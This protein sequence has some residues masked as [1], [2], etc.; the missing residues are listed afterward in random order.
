MLGIDWVLVAALVG[1]GAKA[2][3]EIVKVVWP[4]KAT[5]VDKWQSIFE[6]A[7]RYVEG[8]KVKEPLNSQRAMGEGWEVVKR[9]F[10]ERSW[11]PTESAK[12]SWEQFA[13]IRSLAAKAELPDA[14]RRP[15]R[16]I[17]RPPGH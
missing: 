10:V 16:E 3:A 1:I 17:K 7:W 6:T 9:L 15:T 13:E 12:R 8:L 11:L 4:K 14:D 5:K 2:V